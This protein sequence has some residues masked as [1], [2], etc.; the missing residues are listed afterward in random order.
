ME[1]GRTAREWIDRAR[2]ATSGAQPLLVRAE[3][4]LRRARR[5]A[6]AGRS[7]EEPVAAGLAALAEARQLETPDI[8]VLLDEAALRLVASRWKKRAGRP[9]WEEDLDFARETLAAARER[10][11]RDSRLGDLD[12]ALEE[13]DP[14]AR[15]PT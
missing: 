13:L 12:R 3:L 10:N 14:P 9:G 8:D 11:P 1:P 5:E 6:A 4:E 15:E 7:P 2:V